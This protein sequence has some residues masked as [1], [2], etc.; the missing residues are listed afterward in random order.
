[1]DKRKP[2]SFGSDTKVTALTMKLKAG[3]LVQDKHTSQ[4]GIILRPLRLLGSQF[5]V[6]LADSSV[7]IEQDHFLKP[8]C[9]CKDDDG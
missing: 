8:L 1:M 2:G 5:Y 7:I 3:D 4:F 9:R 6:L